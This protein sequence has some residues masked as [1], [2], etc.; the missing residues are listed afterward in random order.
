M[1][2]LS[3]IQWFLVTYYCPVNV[4]ERKRFE[5]HLDSQVIAAICKLYVLCIEVVTKSCQIKWYYE[6]LFLY[7]YKLTWQTYFL[8]LLIKKSCHFGFVL[9]IY[10]LKKSHIHIIRLVVLLLVWCPVDNLRQETFARLK[11]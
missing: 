5:E 9:I 10:K 8:Y 3:G 6:T 7:V 1:S 4:H 2:S 11:F